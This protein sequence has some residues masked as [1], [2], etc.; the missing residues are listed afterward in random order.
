MPAIIHPMTRDSARALLAAAGVLA[1]A[2]GG[3]SGG[4]SAPSP[5]TT[6]RVSVTYP[7]D[8]DTIY[9][10]DEVQCQAT[11]S[12]SGSGAQAATN[13]TWESD[14]PGVA[15]VSSS[16]LVTGVSPGEATISA[17]VP[18]GGARLATH[19]S[20]PGVPWTLGGSPERDRNNPAAGLAGIG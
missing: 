14:A 19:P 6:S 4:P 5:A 10:G 17:D 16:A 9:I 7:G 8:H 12:S 3:D 18:G 2:C 11:T 1:V 13:A 20:L 15:T